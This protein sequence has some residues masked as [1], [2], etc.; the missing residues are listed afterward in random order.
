MSRNYQAGINH[1]NAYLVSGA[2]YATSSLAVPDQSGGKALIVGFPSITKEVT[3]RN[4]IP[5]SSA[6][7]P[8]RIGFSENGVLGTDPAKLNYIVLNNGESYT[9]KWK[10]SDIY[11]AGDSSPTSASVAASLTGIKIPATFH[12]QYSQSVGVG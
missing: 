1:A 11:L 12:A 7:A 2:P 9:G 5:T 4:T 3:V 6:Q 8:L 10:L